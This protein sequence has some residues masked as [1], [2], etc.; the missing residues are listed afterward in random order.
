MTRQRYSSVLLCALLALLAGCATMEYPPAVPAHMVAPPVAP[1][2]PPLVCYVPQASLQLLPVSLQT[3]T[4]P[5]TPEEWKLWRVVATPKQVC[6]GKGKQRR[7]QGAPSSTVEDANTHAVVRPTPAHTDMGHSAQVHYPYTPAT[8]QIFEVHVSPTEATYLLLPEG[9]RGAA[10]L[11]LNPEQWEVSYGKT[12]AEGSRREVVAVRPVTAPQEARGLLVLQSGAT[13]HLKLLARERPGML[14]VSWELADGKPPEPPSPDRLAPTFDNARA[15]DGYVFGVVGKVTYPPAWMPEAVVDDG[16]N[17][18]IRFPGLGEGLRLPIVTG[19]KQ[20]GKPAL[21]QSRLYIRPEHGAWLY[22]QGLWPAL[23]LSDDAGIKVRITR[24]PP[25][26]L[27]EVNNAS[28]QST[29]ARPA[30]PG[31]ASQF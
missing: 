18:L 16:K 12:G 7:C 10:K 6:R 14:S 9:E 17:T 28:A 30:L 24:Q 23:E 26:A 5:P 8:Q 25:T 11:L 15:Y 21:A 4:R 20:N 13:L 19:I 3:S 2:T 1:Y 31:S 22:V 29:R 27:T